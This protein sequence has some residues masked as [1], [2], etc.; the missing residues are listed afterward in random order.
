MFSRI[1][2]PRTIALLIVLLALSALAYGFAAA[3]TVS[4]TVLGD[5]QADVTG[6]TVSVS[7]TLDATDPGV[8]ATAVVTFQP[9]DTPASAYVGV[10]DDGG[11]TWTWSDAC[12]I[13]GNV[14]TCAFSNTYN[15]SAI[16][17]VRVVAGD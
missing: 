17:K 6:Y 2:R 13:A 1:L 14:A 5:G 10:S 3:N 7:W 16:N 8:D 15:V 12:G 9:A 11:A 4:A